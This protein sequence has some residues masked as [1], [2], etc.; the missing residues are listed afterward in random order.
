MTIDDVAAAAGVSRMTVSRVLRGGH[1]VRAPLQERVFAAVKKLN[2]RLNVSARALAGSGPSR[3]GLVY[4]NPSQAFLSELLTGALKE[5]S[6]LGMQLTLTADAETHDRTAEIDALLRSGVQAFVLPSPACD[7]PDVLKLLR[8]AQARWVAI[9]PAN[10]EIHRFSVSADHFDIAGRMTTRL[11]ELGHRHIGF[12]AGSATSKGAAERLRGHLRAM[13]AAGI[14][15]C[16]VEQGAFT[17]QS[18]LEAT[19]KMLASFPECTAIIACNDDMAA[20]AI[21]VAHRHHLDVPRDLTVVGFDDTPIASIVSPAITTARQP[22]AE[23]AQSAI[24]LLHTAS[25]LTSED[26]NKRTQK[27]LPCTLIERESSGPPRVAARL[28]A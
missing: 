16:P 9:S 20:A 21:S 27:V 14:K 6:K 2:Y 4:S 8:E 18:G 28:R 19:E 23:M 25:N 5:S 7:A 17:F 26:D 13:A 12:I 1:L 10:L 24:R 3:V 22:I 11:I 15:K